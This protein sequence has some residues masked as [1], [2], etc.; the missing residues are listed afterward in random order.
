MVLFDDMIVDM[1]SNKNL[2]SIVTE[3]F[4]RGTKLDISLVFIK[5]SYFKVPKGTLNTAQF[6]IVKT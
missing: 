1:L 6:F 3:L 5:Q 4:L 2:V